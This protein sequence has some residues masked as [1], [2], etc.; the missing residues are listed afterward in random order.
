MTKRL[1]LFFLGITII[2]FGVAL[3]LKTSI[4]SDPFTLFTQGLSFILNTTP[5]RANMVILICTTLI[6]VL[7][8]RKRIKIGTV[9][10]AFGVGPIIDMCLWIVS[11]LPIDSLNIVF[12]CLILVGGCFVIAIGFSILSATEV[13]VAP[14]DIIPFIL[15]D[16]TKLQYKYVRIGLDLT[17]FILGAL[18]GGIFGIGTIIAIL[19]QGPFIQICLPYGEK[20]VK[21][22]VN[23]NK[24]EIETAV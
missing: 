14:N 15:I 22:I 18:F 6:I 5:G 23:F 20:V 13:G 24:E 2:Q 7:F 1:I 16:K 3:F 10:C 4:G 17:F 21:Q 9:I 8:D 19:V 11:Y 12:K